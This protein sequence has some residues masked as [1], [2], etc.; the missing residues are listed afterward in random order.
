V[1]SVPNFGDVP[2][3]RKDASK[4]VLHFFV[5]YFGARIPQVKRKQD[6]L[7]VPSGICIFRFLL[8]LLLRRRR[9]LRMSMCVLLGD[10]GVT[11]REKLF[12][13]KERTGRD[14]RPR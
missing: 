7:V 14:G 12:R 3:C 10:L 8:F 6:L 2:R 1:G 4:Q 11:A 5:V 13:G 9:W